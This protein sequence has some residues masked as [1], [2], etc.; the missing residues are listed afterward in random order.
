MKN[1]YLTESQKRKLSYAG[2]RIDE[3]TEKELL[4]IM[5]DNCTKSEAVDHLSTG[6]Q[7]MKRMILLNFLNSTWMNGT[8]TKK[9]EQNT[10]ND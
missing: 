8:A 3:E 6:Q 1:I 9:N 5:E 7:F 2:K 4:I 10:K